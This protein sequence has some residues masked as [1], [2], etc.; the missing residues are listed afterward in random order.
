MNKKAKLEMIRTKKPALLEGKDPD[1]LSDQEIETLARMAAELSL[2][3]IRDLVRQAIHERFDVGRK[4]TD[5]GMIVDQSAF[6][7]EV[8]PSFLIYS[9][10]SKFYKIAWSIM[11]GK[12]T[13]GETPIEVQNTWVEARTA[14]MGLGAENQITED[15]FFL[16]AKMDQA[17]NPEG[18]EWDVLIT[19]P[20]FTKNGYFQPDS[21]LSRADT[22]AAF[23]G[24]DVNLYEMPNGATHVPGPLFDIKSLLVKNKIGWLDNVQHVAGVGLKGIVHFLESAKWLGQ[25]MLAAMS[26]GRSI[27]GL[28]W[29]AKIRGAM[30][31]IEGKKVIRIDGFNRADSLDVVSRPA[32]GGKFIRAVAGM[33]A[34]NEED[35]MKKKLLALIKKINPALL[36]GKDEAALSDQEVEV[37]ARMAMDAP[38]DQTDT[39]N[40]A[41]KD[42]LAIMRCGMAL[43]KKLADADLGLPQVSVERIRGQFE[44][45]AF[46]SEDLDKAITAE[47]EYLAKINTQNPGV[48]VVG[49]GSISGGLGSF[50]R[51]CMAADHMFGLKKQDMIDMAKLRRLDG[52]AFFADVRSVQDYDGFDDVPAFSSLREM[53]QYFTG[54]AEVSGKFNRKAL[55]PELRSSMDITSATFTYVIGNTLGRRLVGIYKAMAFLEEKLI[56]IKKPVKDFRAQEAV[57]VGGF[58]DLETADPESGDYKEIAGVTDEEST[59]AVAGKGN[60]LSITRK[61]IINDDVT[62]IQRLIDGLGRAAR[63]THAKYVWALITGNANCS[64]G[65]AMFT[66]GHG[67]LGST[68]LSHTTAL[69]AYI[70]LGKMT[71][72]DS[73]ERIGLL[74][75]PS[76]KPNL[77]GPI[78]L[79]TTIDQIAN[80]DDYFTSND[81]T[82]KTRN[83]LKGKVNGV[84]NSLFTD[85][86]N[87]VMLLPPEVI[88]LIEMGYLNGKEEP[89]LLVAD[90]V[91]AEQ[92]F[93]ADKIRY[94]IRH[95]YA[96][97]NIDYRGGYGAIVT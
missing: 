77:I 95:E 49:A 35:I 9:L 85:V 2:D 70:A 13:L 87:W 94:K 81:L 55:A 1:K 52:K 80:D 41:T 21:M 37:I 19:E 45:R 36:E 58:P 74:S 68:A 30:D 33:P 89:E 28:S 84:V 17:K 59:Y 64:D 39:K 69:A 25:N 8:Y 79:M 65:T 48:I 10:E 50:E 53:Y 4:Q 56:S 46:A 60:I 34:P 72:K 63:R 54:D 40:L 93:V 57:L 5:G 97:A 51:A 12:V 16:I 66:G 27:Y 24:L 43:D 14:A 38:G 20:G 82:T 92:V 90:G 6:L 47:K 15:E 32:A 76:I 62:I 29:D 86:N 44:G 26:Q 78:D 22:A 31:V 3:D 75:D 88:D 67:N 61:M 96:G 7:E 11:D 73:G 83:G 42:E 91:Q 23:E 71:E 18:T